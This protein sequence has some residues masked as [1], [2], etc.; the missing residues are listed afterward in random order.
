MHVCVCMCRLPTCPYLTILVRKLAG[1]MD[2]CPYFSRYG[3][4]VSRK[5]GNRDVDECE[6]VAS[7]ADCRALLGSYR[8]L[9]F[10]YFKPFL[11][12]KCMAGPDWSKKSVKTMNIN[13]GSNLY[14]S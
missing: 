6:L 7:E 12:P 5:Y 4:R 9:T 1:S 2:V 3:H 14:R 13:F 8:L 10:A 11:G